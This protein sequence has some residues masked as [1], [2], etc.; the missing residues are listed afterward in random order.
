M[1]DHG[2]E[3]RRRRHISH[4][5]SVLLTY[6]VQR[7]ELERGRSGRPASR[8]RPTDASSTRVIADKSPPDGDQ[9]QIVE[10][11]ESVICSN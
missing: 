7:V 10:K 6:S 8:P 11:E 9:I 5:K 3:V 2:A 4:L 1:M